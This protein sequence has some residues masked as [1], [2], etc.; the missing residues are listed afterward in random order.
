MRV[1]VPELEPWVE[2]FPRKLL[3]QH[4]TWLGLLTVCR[5]FLE[6]PRPG[7][8]IR[9]LP[10]N[11][12]TKFIEQHQGIL[13]ELLEYLL[14][15][16]SIVSD[17]TSFQQRFGLREEEPLIHIRFL[18]DQLRQRYG[19]PLQEL[20]TPGSQL[21]ELDFSGQTCVITENK[22]TFLTLPPLANTFAI[23]GGGFKVSS[24]AAIS[25]LRDC[26]II[27]WGDLD[28]QGF[29]ILSQLRSIFPHV[30]S[31][32]MDEATL[33]A[34]AEFSVVGTP[35]RVRQ[36]PHLTQE[37]HALF[38]RLAQDEKRL[39]QEHIS[40]AYALRQIQSSL[41]NDKA[42]KPTLLNGDHMPRG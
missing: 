8:Y 27:Y 2:R 23:L 42:Q 39:E 35:C 37:E 10:V 33:L 15:A 6:H 26:P 41:R 31:L 38:L 11:V 12:H 29:Q 3:E 30:R 4:N 28:A 1:E 32:M 36:L 13:R 22:M 21:V 25:W 19:V 18:D 7:L 34:F 40:H 24:L 9:E 17:A 16:E 14:P 20:S 5:Y